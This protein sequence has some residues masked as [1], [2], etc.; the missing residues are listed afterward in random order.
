M[1]WLAAP[2]AL[3][4]SACALQPMYAGGASSPVARGLASVEVAP[5]EGRAGWLVRNALVDRLSVG[6]QADKS[7]RLEVRLDDSLQ[8]LGVLSDDAISRERRTLR[9]R[10]QL[11]DAA[12]GDILLDA[13]A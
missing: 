5:I 13:P 7:Y 3:L 9:A 1:K 12:S 6:G 2:A 11:I 4:L 10:Y 8:G